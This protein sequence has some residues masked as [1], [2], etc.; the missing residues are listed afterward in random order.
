MSRIHIQDFIEELKSLPQ[1]YTL[2]FHSLRSN[3]K[4][5]NQDELDISVNHKDKHIVL[6]M[7]SNKEI[8]KANYLELSM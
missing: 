4:W 2:D 6:D 3:L 7:Y 5:E 1:D 8:Y